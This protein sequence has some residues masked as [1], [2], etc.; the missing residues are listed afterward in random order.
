MEEFHFN[1]PGKFNGKLKKIY[2]KFNI[3]VRCDMNKNED[4]RWIFK[5]YR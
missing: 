1:N 5:F 4:S 2:G 3:G